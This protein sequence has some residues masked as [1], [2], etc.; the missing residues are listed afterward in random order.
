M[1]HDSRRCCNPDR[2]LNS[3][4]PVLWI[5]HGHDVAGVHGKGRAINCLCIGI[6][7]HV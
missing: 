5:F 1:A 7:E 3:Q 2:H 4:D 6:I